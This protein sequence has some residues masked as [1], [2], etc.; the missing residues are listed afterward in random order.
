MFEKTKARKAE[1]KAKKSLREYR[2]ALDYDVYCCFYPMI[3]DLK[4]PPLTD[5]KILEDL[6]RIY[7]RV[8][9][10]E[11]RE[12]FVGLV[13]KYYKNYLES[14][15]RKKSISSELKNIFQQVKKES[16]VGS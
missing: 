3:R 11:N 6:T 10:N 7:N 5:S 14:Q 12:Y 8:T 13:R 9:Q 1:E 16:Q 15:L 2:E 4:D